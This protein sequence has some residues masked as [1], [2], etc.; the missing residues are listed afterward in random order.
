MA[1]VD[2]RVASRSTWLPGNPW[3]WM[4]VGLGSTGLA[5][6]VTVAFRDSVEPLRL[7]LV[8]FGLLAAGGAL[9]IRL[10]S[11]APAFLEALPSERRKLLT[12]G[13]VLIFGALALTVTVLLAI[14]L[15]SNLDLP[16]KPGSLFL[17]WLVVVPA[18]YSAARICSRPEESGKKVSPRE[19]AAALL[20]LAALVCVFACFAL[21]L[22]QARAGE[23]E[24]IRLLLAV[25]AFVS[26]VAA[27]LMV[28]P[29]GVRRGVVS[30]LILLH[31]GG[32]CTAVLSSPPTPWIVAQLWTRIYRPYL[33]FM[34][35]NNAYHFYSPDPGPATYLWF[36]LIYEDENGKLHGHWHKVPDFDERGRPRY[37]V[38]LTYQRLLALTENITA[39]TSESAVV[40]ERDK[41]TGESQMK[42]APFIA[43]RKRYL[44]EYKRLVIE[45][46]LPRGALK[47]PLHPNV[48]LA[49]QYEPPVLGV[50]NILE[51]Y[52]RHA[53][54]TPHPEHPEWRVRRV[55][56]YRVIHIIP[57]DTL[58]LHGA[59][60]R[61]PEFYRPYYV[62]DF[63]PDGM[64]LNPTDPFLYWLMPIFRDLAG[65]VHDYARRHAGDD[66]WIGKMDSDAKN[67][68]WT[69][70]HQE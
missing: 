16:W 64:L 4:A 66:R 54:R 2:L 8:F 15:F 24:T 51:S 1:S 55:K 44:P 14:R 20:V 17:I 60:P 53:C 10:N 12:H 56:V 22:G 27:P 9:V 47:I 46:E 43:R 59:D 33:E 61:D 50:K 18:S 68:E 48:P 58:Y 6:A 63:D 49:L 28:V 70:E 31:F 7:L 40:F 39:K 52:A 37:T 69:R 5:W 32:I 19:E 34:Y 38:A 45:P 57:P 13:L 42:D 67:I 25:M 3:F 26:L 35:L 41:V 65:N 29:Q 11:Q 36:R 21:Y 23:W 62:G 30:L